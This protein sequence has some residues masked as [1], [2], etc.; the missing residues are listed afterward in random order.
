MWWRSSPA[1]RWQQGRTRSEGL[2]AA[3]VPAA[4]I[5]R[6]QRHGRNPDQGAEAALAALA[7]IQHVR[8][9]VSLD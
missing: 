9:R 8:R 7:T 2:G 4:A 6:L 5:Y 1:L 3:P